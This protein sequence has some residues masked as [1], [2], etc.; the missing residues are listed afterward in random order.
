VPLSA[1]RR[2]DLLEWALEDPGRVVLE[3][4]YDGE[5]RYDRQPV[6]ALQGRAP[7]AVV[8][9]GSAAKTL[10]P[11]LRLAWMVVPPRLRDAVVAAK[12]HAD[13]ATEAVGQLTLAELIASHVYDRHVRATRLRYRRRS[14]LLTQVL[15]RRAGRTARARVPRSIAAGLQ[16]VVHVPDEAEVLDR[17][18][19]AGLGLEGLAEHFHG[20]RGRPG[21]VVGFARPRDAAY[22]RALEVLARVLP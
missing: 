16:T 10:A 2:R 5:F 20:G 7:D 14:D 15:E 22:P 18:T 4:D 1:Q 3:D 11:G 19:R 12:Q 13:L 21:V 17:A 6:G 8:Y 9:V